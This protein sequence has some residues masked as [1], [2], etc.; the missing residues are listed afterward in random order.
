[1]RV[2]KE[3]NG[4]KVNGI[5]G[6]YV[7]LLAFDLLESKCNNLMGFSIHRVDHNENESY[8]LEG[9]KAFAETDPGFPSGSLYSTKDHPIQSFQWADYSAKPGYSYTYTITALKGQPKNLVPFAETKIEI[10]TEKVEEDNH[11]VY[12]NRGTAAS[13]EY[14]R[15]FGDIRPKDV[16]NN[17]AFEWLSRGI[18]EALENYVNSCEKGKHSLRIAAYEFNY[19]PFLKLLKT[20]IDEG[21]DIKIVYDSRKPSPKKGNLAAIA[22]CN[23]GKYCK[24]RKEGASYISHN[25]FII[26]LENEDPISVWTG[27]M[28]FSEGGIFGH[29][30]V[31]HVV[32]NN[33]KVANE[34]FT[35][36]KLLN[37]DLNMEDMKANIETITPL[38]SSLPIQYPDICVFSPRKTLDALGLYCKLAMSA[39]EGLFMTFAFGIN[40]VFKDV[41][42]NSNASLRFALLE[43][44]T[45]P[46][47]KGPAKDAEE[48]EIQELRNMTE[49]V[50][51]IGDFI[52]TN[53]LDGWVK[54][55]LSGLNSNVRYIHNKFMLIDPL[56]ENPI[57]ITGSANFS[58]ASTNEN[59]E[60]MIIIKDNKRVADIYIGE[61][62]RLFSHHSFRE[63]LKWRKPNTPPKPLRTDNWWS[64]YF[65]NTPRSLI[66]KYFAQKI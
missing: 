56:S 43:K 13:Q 29:S 12:F 17:K 47:K 60:N 6:T 23:L 25:K 51:A 4:L 28:N 36:W 64:D 66:R 38:P 45:R 42:R 44:A 30:N 41:F 15:R 61:Y 26:K 10:T 50:F 7:V 32:T 24:G 16:P 33:P 1:M 37:G 54:E 19:E 46:M 22:K 20:K 40:K 58:N 53:K 52:K 65:G 34:Y 11:N 31:A 21:I 18:Y 48:H 57:I 63:S 2:S 49:N 55:S 59:D 35:Y 39:K 3:S 8:F 62:M 9:M 5:A 14:M 27:G